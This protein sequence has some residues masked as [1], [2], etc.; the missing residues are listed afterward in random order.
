MNDIERVRDSITVGSDHLVRREAVVF[1]EGA[2]AEALEALDRIEAVVN[3]AEAHGTVAVEECS[4]CREHHP[5]IK[6]PSKQCVWCHVMQWAAARAAL[7]ALHK[8]DGAL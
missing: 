7:D 1:A 5:D 4:E 6:D 2:F 8:D 3:A